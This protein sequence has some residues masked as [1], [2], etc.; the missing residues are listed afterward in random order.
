MGTDLES[1][2]GLVGLLHAFGTSI[3]DENAVVVLNRPA[4]VEAVKLGAELFRQAMTDE[5][6]G[7]DIPSN[8]RYLLSGRGSL[9]MN[10]VAAIRALE[11]Q[12]PELAAEVGL[13]PVRPD[14]RA[15]RLPT[16]SAP[17]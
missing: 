3:Q 7:W 14:R 16:R 10:A 2:F 9:I 12:D 13:L 1:S 8:N 4:T 15:A 11:D 17:G 6:L 5:V